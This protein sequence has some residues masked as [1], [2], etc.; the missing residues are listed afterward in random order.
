MTCAQCGKLCI[1][2]ICNI[3]TN[4]WPS[5]NLFSL[6]KLSDKFYIHSNVI[7]SSREVKPRKCRHTPCINCHIAHRSW[8]HFKMKFL[9]RYVR[10]LCYTLK[11]IQTMHAQNNKD[12][13]MDFYNSGFQ[14]EAEMCLGFMSFRAPPAAPKQ[15][16]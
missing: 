10:E 7:R 6:P 14:G 9:W 3:S 8:Q 16:N 5:S 1:V 4:I 12:N 13:C 15:K 2:Y 11:L